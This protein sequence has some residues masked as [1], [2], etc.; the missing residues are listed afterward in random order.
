MA[1]RDDCPDCGEL[2][3]DEGLCPY[4]GYGGFG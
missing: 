3:D 2:L 4:C 1:E